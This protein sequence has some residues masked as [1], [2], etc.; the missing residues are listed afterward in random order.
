LSTQK[1]EI[2]ED[3]ST[4]TKPPRKPSLLVDPSHRLQA[5]KR[6]VTFEPIDV[7]SLKLSSPEPQSEEEEDQKVI[8]VLQ[9]L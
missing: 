3:S 7:A 4:P 9:W 5:R 8:E 2:V 1:I 6:S